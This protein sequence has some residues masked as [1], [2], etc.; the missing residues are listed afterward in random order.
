M[1]CPQGVLLDGVPKAEHRACGASPKS[2]LRCPLFWLPLP[3]VLSSAVRLRAFAQSYPVSSATTL[4]PSTPKLKLCLLNPKSSGRAAPQVPLS[5]HL[6]VAHVPCSFLSLGGRS[7][8]C[9]PASLPS[10]ISGG[11]SLEQGSKHLMNLCS[12]ALTHLSN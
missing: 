7:S 5:C 1:L 12:T 11:F 9:T 8:V 2:A 10:G 6:L 3:S 4:S